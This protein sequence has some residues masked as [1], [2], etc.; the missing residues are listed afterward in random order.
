M[1]LS[2]LVEELLLELSPDEIHNKYYKNIPPG[3]FYAIVLSDPQTVIDPES[4]KIQKVGKYT[5][6]LLNLF[7]NGKL[8]LED[9]TKVK[10]YLQYAY[11][12]HVPLDINKIQNLSDIYNSVKKYMNVD[13]HD[14]GVI[15]D[16]L[17]SEDDYKVLLNGNEWLILQPLNEKASCYLGVGT[18]W[19]TASGPYSLTK[20]YQDRD[21]HYDRYHKQGPLYIII[22][23]ADNK[24]KYQF[25]FE[26]KQF[27]DSSDRTIKTGELLHDNPEIRNYFFPSFIKEVDQTEIDKELSE[28]TMLSQDD[29]LEIIQNVTGD[30]GKNPLVVAIL[31]KNQ[32]HVNILIDDEN[33]LKHS[34]FVDDEEIEFDIKHLTDELEGVDGALSQL[35]NDKQ[36]SWNQ[37]YNDQ[38]ES[39]GSNDEWNGALEPLFK[40]YFEGNTYDVQYELGTPN[41]K[42]FYDTYFLL[43]TED[44]SIQD[45]YIDNITRKSY[46]SYEDNVQSE[47]NDIEKYISIDND[48]V[49]VNTIQ[50][51]NFLSKN[52]IDHIKDNLV[53]TL[54]QYIVEGGIQTTDFEF[55][56]NYETEYPNY[57][58]MESAINKF[59]QDLITDIDNTKQCLE[60]RELF[61]NIFKRIFKNNIEYENEHVY[62]RILDT[63][64]DC[65]N[66]TVSIIYKNK[67][68]KKEYRGNVKV[69]NLPVYATNYELFEAITGQKLIN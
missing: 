22:N 13:T 47:I 62:I 1:N 54:N 4:K 60:Y 14:L 26:T 21:N 18:Q 68:K 5:K 2:L 58:D 19:C 36:N 6:I 37:I 24:I 10:E 39:F 20:G 46:Q 11:K 69:K 38:Y 25:H 43:F 50:F 23:K 12:Y 34:V 3:S 53:T 44:D 27:M 51:I 28:L 7:Q 33:D 42:T 17:S 52:N 45:E 64:V 63:K 40:A 8:R 57:K 41:Y 48:E 35:R 29:A 30:T 55:Y 66:G 9:E 65:V 32:E 67:D 56:Y 16:S 15:M 59:F 61:N 49:K 31:S